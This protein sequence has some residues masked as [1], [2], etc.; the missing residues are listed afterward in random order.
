M[1]T[2]L[3][4]YHEWSCRRILANLDGNSDDGLEATLTKKKAKESETQD[5]SF[6]RLNGQ[7]GNEPVILLIVW[8]KMEGQENAL[9]L[10]ENEGEA[11][12]SISRICCAAL[13]FAET[14]EVRP[15]GRDIVDPILFLL[16][17]YETEVPRTAKASL[18]NLAENNNNKLLNAK[19]GGLE[20]LILQGVQRNSGG[21]VNTCPFEGREM[22]LQLL[23]ISPIL[24][25]TFK[26]LDQ[27]VYVGAIPVLV[28]LLNSADAV[29]QNYCRTA[30]SLAFFASLI[31]LPGA[32]RKKLAS[33]EPK[34]F[35][36]LG[37]LM[38]RA[39]R[40][41]DEKYQLKIVRADGLSL[42]RRLL[43][44]AYP[45]LLLSSAAGVRNVSNLASYDPSYNLLSFK[46]NEEVQRRAISTL[47]D[48]AASP[49]KSQTVPAKAGE[50]ESIKEL[51]LEV[52]NCESQTQI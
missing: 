16:S 26:N 31:E 11:T 44:S 37:M 23:S 42:L 28:S 33:S 39:S 22:P 29:V 8:K 1:S 19:L 49:E 3:S 21:C 30:Q 52:Q 46:E 20:P 24:V 15:V 18:G 50:E 45:P 41:T 35:L 32:N 12:F 43:R 25:I 36:S 2:L 5:G 27:L 14:M 40:A 6:L 10:L 17:R 7:R 9:P 4:D 51:V 38:D 47:H 34:L 13:V 48:R